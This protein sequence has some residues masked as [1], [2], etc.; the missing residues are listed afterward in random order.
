MANTSW[1][2]GLSG[3]GRA[4]LLPVAGLERVVAEV[5]HDGQHGAEVVHL[6]RAQHVPTRLHHMAVSRLRRRQVAGGRVVG[7]SVQLGGHLV[8]EALHDGVGGHALGAPV[9]RLVVRVHDLIVGAAV[10]A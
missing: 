2:V 8:F 5:V 10:G 6:P 3:L 1:L 9:R 7:G 4:R